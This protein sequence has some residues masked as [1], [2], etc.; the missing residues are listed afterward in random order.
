MKN[1]DLMI[2]QMVHELAKQKDEVKKDD[3]HPRLM[4]FVEEGKSELIKFSNNKVKVVNDRLAA[5][6]SANSLTFAV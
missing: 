5:S 2:W 1:Y 6:L 3:L 4:G